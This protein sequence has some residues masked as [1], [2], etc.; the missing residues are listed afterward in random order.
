MEGSPSFANDRIQRIREL[1]F[2]PDF[3]T[4]EE[5]GELLELHARLAATDGARF[6]DGEGVRDEIATR[7]RRSATRQSRS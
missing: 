4:S 7:R 3:L 1:G 6:R 2:D 5:Q